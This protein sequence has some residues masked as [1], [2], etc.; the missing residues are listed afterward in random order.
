MAELYDM[1]SV[2][3]TD[4]INNEDKN[5]VTIVNRTGSSL[6]KKQ[7]SGSIS[8][9]VS[10]SFPRNYNIM[11]TLGLPKKLALQRAID[12]TMQHGLESQYGR[13]NAAVN[14]NN[15]S[16]M[17]SNGKTIYYATPE[18]NDTAIVNSYLHNPNWM[19]A[20]NSSNSYDYFYN[21]Q[22]PRANERAYEGNM[23][24]TNDYYN[25]IKEAKTLQK[26]IDAYIKAGNTKNWSMNV[27]RQDLDDM[28]VL[29]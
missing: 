17:M 8:D 7:K 23:I 25:K 13:S 9:F 10:F 24:N 27:T 15:R 19:R 28:M 12:M 20:I 26:T 29:S 22:H 11:R 6:Q 2:N 5:S 1:Y 21:L 16:G 3:N 18:L 14:K 4:E